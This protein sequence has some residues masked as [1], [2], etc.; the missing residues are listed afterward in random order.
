MPIRSL[1]TGG[2]AADDIQ[3]GPTS[4][5]IYGYDPASVSPDSP[6]LIRLAAGFQQPLFAAASPDI[7]NQLFVVEQGGLIR[8][9]DTSTGTVADQPFLD[10]SGEILT[11]GE[12][13]L[14]GLALAPDFGQGGRFFVNLVNLKGDTEIREYRSLPGDATRADPASARIVLTVDQPGFTN[15]KAGWLAFGPDGYLYAA[16]GDGGGGGDPSGNAQNPDSLLGKILRL[17]AGSDAFPADPGRNYGIPSD[18]PFAAGAGADEVWAMGLRNPWRSGF[19]RGL[20]DL[21]IGDVGQTRW[22]EVDLGAPGANYGWS[23][24]EG[25]EPFK[26]GTPSFGT[27]TPP[28]FAYGRDSGQ[29][30]VGGFVYR[31]DAE[32]MQG[33]Y[34]F[35][36]FVSGRVW[37]LLQAQGVPIVTERSGLVSPDDATLDSPSSFGEDAVGNLY[38]VDY[39]GDLFRLD[40]GGSSA[41]AGD[42][43]RG[44]GG[45][46]MIFA[47][48]GGDVVLGEDGDDELRGQSGNDLLDGGLGSDV[49]QGGSGLDTALFSSSR[50]ALAIGIQPHQVLVSGIEGEDLLR[51]VER[52][53]FSDGVLALDTS[54][55]AAQA[56]RLYGAALGR[57]PDAGGLGFHVGRLDAGVPLAEV[58]AGFIASPEFQGSFGQLDDPAFVDRLYENFRGGD[59]DGPVIAYHLGRLQAG[60]SRESVLVDFSESPEN[61]VKAAPMMADGIWFT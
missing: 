25:D 12:Q 16:L 59:G 50:T 48:S 44:G 45:G 14:L 19:D 24:L 3:G 55:V 34:L 57:E 38:L 42:S 17:D 60:F 33:E 51:D 32:A 43:L 58:A 61:Q 22:E 2:L 30:I 4:D 53:R 1:A 10:V 20:G 40:P 56:Y 21:W 23:L 31:G 27:P 46:D 5:L 28:V 37:S 54:G 15:H 7:P 36:D 52:I 39:D 9:L 26:S 49:I 8:I 13:G 6:G 11:R 41:D 29:S 35:A 47:G 18:N